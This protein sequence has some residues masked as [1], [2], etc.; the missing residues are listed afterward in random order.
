MT[1]ARS[2]AAK[3]VSLNLFSIRLPF[4]SM[5]ALDL[6]RQQ[7][8]YRRDTSSLSF[9]MQRR[10][11]HRLNS[12]KRIQHRIEAEKNQCSTIPSLN[13]KKNMFHVEII[14]DPLREKNKRLRERKRE[15]DSEKG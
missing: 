9:N 12:R 13:T 5:F 2:M 15:R 6:H 10:E 7:P 3:S 11:V 1:L 4:Q 8:Y 14:S